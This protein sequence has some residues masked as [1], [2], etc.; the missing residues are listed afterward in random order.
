VELTRQVERRWVVAGLGARMHY[1]VP[2]MLNNA[3]L[4]A[5]F[6]TDFYTGALARRV[7][8]LVPKPWRNSMINGA[9]GRSVPDLAIKLVHS[10]PLLGLE[11]AIAQRV[12]K[13]PDALTKLFLKTGE[14]FGKAVA[15]DGFADA[16]GLYCFN[17]AAY[18]ALFAAKEACLTT[19]LEQTIAP[20]AIEERILAEEQEL[21]PGW[22]LAPSGK[23]SAIEATIAREREE[24]Q[25][26]DRIFC[27]SEF[28]RQ[29]VIDSGGAAHK[30]TVVPYGVEKGFSQMTRAAHDGPLRILTVG[31][32]NLRKGAGYAYEVGRILG[33]SAELRWVGP[34]F[35]TVQ[36]RSKMERH[37]QLTGAIPRSQILE[38]FRWADVFFLPSVCEG[39][40]TV[41]YEAL[42]CGLPVITTPNAGSIVVDG[43]N[44]FIVPIRDTAQMAEKLSQLPDNQEL[45]RK[46]R[47]QAVATSKEASLEAYERRIL[48]A[49]RAALNER[50][51]L[52]SP[53]TD[54]K[55]THSHLCRRLLDG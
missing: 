13:H 24:W 37:V 23:S 42:M 47:D 38:Q 50:V 45:R 49:L 25:L 39:S 12:L 21:F 11:Y 44:G 34:I 30:C 14:R 54:E 33:N 36:A 26:A 8:S 40:A 5:R 51:E 27:P 31:Q 17:T 7:L 9:L 32:V 15:R 1:A 20:R 6:Y 10:Y 4:L 41:T 18:H 16:A 55:S 3:G 28:V 43:V 53:F 2:R 48:G 46:M 22:E 19:V 35:L 52:Q 29:G